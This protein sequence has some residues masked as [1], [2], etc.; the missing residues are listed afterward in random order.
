M[1]SITVYVPEASLEA[2]KQAMFA[3]G[4]GKAGGYDQACWQV[5][6]QGQFR[7][8]AGSRPVVGVLN[9]LSCV[10]EYRLE[11]ICEDAALDVAMTAM[12]AAH[13]YEQP[14]YSVVRMESV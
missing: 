12:R 4:A 13:P 9:A 14:A 8:L 5:L 3:A 1:Y 10:S 7:P 11:M 6:G 2:V